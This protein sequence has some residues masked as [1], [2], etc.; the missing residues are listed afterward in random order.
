VHVAGAIDGHNAEE[1]RRVENLQTASTMSTGSTVTDT[2]TDPLVAT[3]VTS[4]HGVFEQL[5][6]EVRSYSRAWPVIFDQARG[7]RLHD[8][9]GNAYIDF[10]S[11][12]GALNYGHNHPL[13]KRALLDYLAED[14]VLHSLD[15]N[16]VA[17]GELLERLRTVVFEPRG[18]SYR[19][20]FP[21][22]TGTN[23]VEAAL[24]LA[25]K[26]TGRKQIVS[27]TNAFHGMTL[28]SLS[29]TANSMKRSGAGV[30]LNDCTHLPYCGFLDDEVDSIQLLEAL[31]ED[32]GSGLDLP[33]A[34][35]VE[36]IQGEGG[37]NV[38]S[39]SWLRRLADLCAAREILL[40]VDD[41][42]MGCGRTGPFFSF[43]DAGIVPDIVIL[44]KSLSGIGLPLALTLIR[45]ELD[46]WEP[47][48]H[49]GTFRGNNTA[50]VTATA[51][52]SMWEEGGFPEG[53][54]AQI[55]Q[56]GL[57]RT[58][59]GGIEESVR[60]RGR[61]VEHALQSI[62]GDVRRQ[63]PDLDV[64]VRG[65]GLVWGL[66]LPEGDMATKAARAAFDR[67]VL[68]ETSGP[69]QDVVKLM[70]PLTVSVE[71]ELMPGLEVLA[72]A[73]DTVVAL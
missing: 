27:F 63:R 30:S 38:A 50:F 2:D 13:L 64:D 56:D 72:E 31:I 6:S 32:R 44:S 57:V 66:A 34:V 49:N 8:T 62:A 7:A 55:D 42:Q 47:G 11:G 43:E 25:R 12:A 29:V 61:V 71:D 10:F 33:A 9:D 15:M 4:M 16:T 69:E 28:G 54:G 20:Q 67:G 60:A 46:V 65:K 39:V 5:E 48:E 3:G 40:I 26:V 18:L 1:A 73:M 37:V 59:G 17:K 23:A 52:L 14:R 70:P 36:T 21:G 24:K 51:A 58:N 53:Q 19:V 68:V 45:P 41:V 35:I 22:P